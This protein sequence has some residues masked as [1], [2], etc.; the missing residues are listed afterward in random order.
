MQPAKPQTEAERDAAYMEQ[1]ERLRRGDRSRDLSPEAI[2]DA[3]YNR[4][5]A[6]SYYGR[7]PLP[8]YRPDF[9]NTGPLITDLTAAQAR[10]YCKGY[11]NNEEHG[12]R[13]DFGMGAMAQYRGDISLVELVAANVK[14]WPVSETES[15]LAESAELEVQARADR[16]R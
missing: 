16:E 15:I 12:A 7:R 3:C 6:D 2:L 5:A 14:D 10:A 13:K 9:G 8:A 4:G 11:V 1:Y